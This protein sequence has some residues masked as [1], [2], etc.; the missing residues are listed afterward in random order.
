MTSG[1]G[2]LTFA[3][4]QPGIQEGRLDLD[5]IFSDK[6][7]RR[8]FERKWSEFYASDSRHSDIFLR[9]GNDILVFLTESLIPL[10]SDGRPSV[11]MLLGNPATHSVFSGMCF[12]FEGANR[13]HRF[14][15]ALR[16]SG[17]LEF[18]SDSSHPWLTRDEQNRIR[19]KE[20][21]SLEY[22][23]PFRIG[24]AVYFSIPSAASSSPWSGVGG[25]QRL[26]G[27]KA[28]CA[29]AAEEQ[30][31]IESIIRVFIRSGGGVVAYQ[32][33]AYEG[34]RAPDA[35]SYQLDLAKRGELHGK[36]KFNSRIHLLGSPPTRILHT[37]EA[38]DVLVQFKT[39]IIEGLD[40]E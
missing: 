39:R 6:S 13:E 37:R 21:F 16:E 4:I 31:R 23:S 28:L 24:I 5:L 22:H 12:S 30:R 3:D 7:N 33:D 17:F 38:R 27:R 11:L 19:K 25:L 18:Y 2:L 9:E 35:P 32:R 8:R 10:K 1:S 29:I 26:F 15:V 20:L 34:I 14:W 36:Y 40:Q